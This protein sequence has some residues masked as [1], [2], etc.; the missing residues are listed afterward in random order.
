MV[1]FSYK[2]LRWMTYFGFFVS[3]VTFLLIPTY[4]I[5]ALLG[6][7]TVGHGFF[8]QIIATLFLGGVQ[9][10]SIGVLGEY[11]G[12]IYEEIKQRPLYVIEE[13]LGIPTRNEKAPR[14]HEGT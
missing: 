4:F 13:T 5:F 10:I 1:S 9:L 11:V 12:R 14:T 2:P 3:F 6:L 8:T 7:G